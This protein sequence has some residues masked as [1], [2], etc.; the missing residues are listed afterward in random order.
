MHSDITIHMVSAHAEGEV[1]NVIV[2]G[3]APPPGAT[4]WDQRDFLQ[5]DQTLRRLVLNEP[6]G[7]VFTHVNLLVPAK[8]PGAIWGFLTMEPEH[9]PPMSGSN[10]M[11]VA[12]VL[13][14]TG[15]VPMVEPETTFRLECAAGLLEVRAFCGGG[16]ARSV[17][18]TNVPAFADRLS[19]PLEVEGLPT[20][21]VDT[22]WGGDSFV[23]VDAAAAGVEITPDGAADLARLGARITRAANEQI[24]FTHPTQPWSLISFCQFTAPV[25]VKDGVKT[26]LSAVVIDPGKIDRSPCGTGCSARL[27][28][29]Q[30]RGEIA[31]G[32]AYVGRSIIGGRFDCR[33]VGTTTLGDRPAIIPSLRGRGF[34]TGTHQIL[35][36]P[37]DPWPLGY[38]LTDTWPAPA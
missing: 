3:V 31:D 15:M 37:A 6:R 22:A 33:I 5:T 9:T 19:V 12:T 35:R 17:E 11:C 34:V 24:G 4:L 30:A 1:G 28:V 32:D 25:T 13:L 20:Q 38:R 2:G 8:H 36:D 16:R 18:I 29:M 26:G 10:S 27:A 14:E 23:L 7:G 21:T